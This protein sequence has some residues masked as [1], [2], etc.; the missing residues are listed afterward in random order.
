MP[1]SAVAVVSVTVGK[2]EMLFATIVFAWVLEEFCILVPLV[3]AFTGG[4]PDRL[5]WN[6]PICESPWL[7]IYCQIDSANITI[8]FTLVVNKNARRRHPEH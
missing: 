2:D 7:R 6:P 1:A 5:A 8:L 4:K 3:N